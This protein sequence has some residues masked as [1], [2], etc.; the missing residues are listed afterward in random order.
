MWILNFLLLPT[1]TRNLI[2]LN[3]LWN[4]ARKI[5]ELMP[6]TVFEMNV[7][8]I[9]VLIFKLMDLQLLI[10]TIDTIEH[11]EKK[12]YYQFLISAQIGAVDRMKDRISRIVIL[13]EW[14]DFEN[15][16]IKFW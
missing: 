1:E 13:E 15:L 10:D 8:Q 9:E 3:K 2:K 5:F 4:K 7:L 6:K 14:K 16:E 12:N 11:E